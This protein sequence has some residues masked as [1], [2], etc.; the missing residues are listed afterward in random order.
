[1]AT[2]KP[3]KETNVKD[4]TNSDE[5]ESHSLLVER[6]VERQEN[7]KVEQQN[8]DDNDQDIEVVIEQQSAANQAID[9]GYGWLVVFGSVFLHFLIGGLERSSGVLFLIFRKKY[10]ESAAA[11]AWVLS[12]AS[13][14]RL[15]AGPLA[16]ALCQ[17]FSHRTVVVAGGII[18]SFGIL[19]CAFALNLLFLFFTYGLLRG[20]GTALA[21]APAVVIVGMYFNKRRGLAVGI[22]TAGV[23]IGTFAVPPFIEVV[24]SYYGHFGSFLILTGYCL[25]I[26]VCGALFRPLVLQK[27]YLAFTKNKKL[28][29]TKDGDAE[30]CLNNQKRTHDE[31]KDGTTDSEKPNGISRTPNSIERKQSKVSLLRYVINRRKSSVAKAIPKDK[32]KGKI[33]EIKLLKDFRFFSYCIAMFL[34]TIAFQSAFVFL[35]SYGKQIGLSDMEGAYVLSVAGVLDTVGRIASGAILELKWIKPYR[36]FAYNS[37]MF[38]L[39]VTCIL[40]PFTRSFLQLAIVAAG[41]GMLTGSYV[42]QKSVIIVD[43][44]G[45]EKLNNS[46]GLLICFQGVGML[47][48]P[49]IAGIFKDRLGQ[50]DEA[51]YFGGSSIMLGALL[52]TLS[53]VIHYLRE[54]RTTDV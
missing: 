25:N 16:S 37:I 13:A 22:A 53:N 20:I 52:L 19:L 6:T 14:I 9:G 30:P 5:G 42:S 12:L 15:M 51:F 2:N 4:P 48:G 32:K 21:Y 35:P 40:I 1:M 27:R 8:G 3:N 36:M 45:P 31:Q 17:K 49:P 43:L 26:M 34:F 50:V 28:K 10:Q 18:C 54:K 11:T 38:F 24:F 33:L 46:F 7:R 41:Y 44:L 23:G 47:I 39:V 29:K